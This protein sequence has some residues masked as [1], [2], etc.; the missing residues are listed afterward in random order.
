MPSL[1]VFNHLITCSSPFFAKA[2]RWFSIV[3][4]GFERL[5]NG[6]TVVA[7]KAIAFLARGVQTAISPPYIRHFI[8]I[9]RMRCAKF[10]V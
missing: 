2:L 10:S 1:S 7:T 6:S 5:L 8:E 9:Y 3:N 4:A